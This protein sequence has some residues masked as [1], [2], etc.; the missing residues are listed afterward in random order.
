MAYGGRGT[1]RGAV[2]TALAALIG[3]T[4]TGCSPALLPLVAVYLDEH[5][6]PQALLRSCEDD[7]TIRGPLLD[8]HP[9]PP[10]TA[11]ASPSTRPAPRSGWQAEGNRKAEDIPLFSP[12]AHWDVETRGPATLRPGVTY[13]L[14]LADPDDSYAYAGEVTFSAADLTA[15]PPGS[16]LTLHGETT[17]E[18][19]E[20]AARDAC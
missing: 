14:S 20:E 17:R 5:G 15:L 6:T 1:T 13:V 2:A 11:G 12:P 9:D 7:G 3:L 10:A 18:E 4:A 8:I 16:V 19:F